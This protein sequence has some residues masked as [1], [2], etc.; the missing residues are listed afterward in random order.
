MKREMTPDQQKLVEA[1]IGLAL[2]MAEGHTGHYEEAR[3]AAMEALCMA[4]LNFKPELK[5][6]FGAYA[7]KCMRGGIKNA[8][9]KGRQPGLFTAV[10]EDRPVPADHRRMRAGLDFEG[11]E[12]LHKVLAEVPEDGRELLVAYYADG[13]DMPTLGAKMGISRQRVSVV[14]SRALETAQRAYR[15]LAA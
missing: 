14:M 8:L 10:F 2:K 9:R 5:V 4:A 11:K 13:I 7:A 12:L 3:M 1:N 15:R 6:P